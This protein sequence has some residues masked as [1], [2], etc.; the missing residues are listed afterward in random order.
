MLSALLRRE[1]MVS[2]L[3]GDPFS[4][5]IVGGIAELFDT[6]F[7]Y[8]DEDLFILAVIKQVSADLGHWMAVART[9]IFGRKTCRW[10]RARTN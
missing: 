4:D 3:R 1:R 2:I 8:N 6:A 9:G 7:M 10:P 5:V